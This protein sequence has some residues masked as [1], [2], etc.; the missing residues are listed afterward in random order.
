MEVEALCSTEASSPTVSP[1]RSVFRVA[2]AGGSFML[3]SVG[4]GALAM[5]T[6][7]DP[8]QLHNDYTV[9]EGMSRVLSDCE[10]QQNDEGEFYVKDIELRW[11]N[12]EQY[13]K[14]TNK[15]V[16]S[17]CNKPDHKLFGLQEKMSYTKFRET[18]ST[19]GKEVKR[20][21][22]KIYKRSDGKL[23]EE[24]QIAWTRTLEGEISFNHETIGFGNDEKARCGKITVNA[25]KYRAMEAK[26]AE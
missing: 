4:I 20:E 23:N 7:S 8:C 6:R 9:S 24:T 17:V 11:E 26:K 13:S 22:I 14:G 12:E 18:V 1:R 5:W 25:R 10:A 19:I 3:F 21:E 16:H 15:W 2:L